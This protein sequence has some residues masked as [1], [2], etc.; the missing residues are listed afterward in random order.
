MPFTAFAGGDEI[1]LSLDTPYDVWV[2]EDTEI[3]RFT[4]TDDGWYRFYTDGD[5]D[6]IISADDA[7][8]YKNF[9]FPISFIRVIHIMSRL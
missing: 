4:P 8:S 5:W 2:G 1:E 9:N 7:Y 3:Y 6:T